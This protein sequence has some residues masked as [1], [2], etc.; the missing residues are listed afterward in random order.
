MSL[1]IETNPMMILTYRFH[2]TRFTVKYCLDIAQYQ[3]L[4]DK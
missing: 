1:E 3:F 4:L 2:Y